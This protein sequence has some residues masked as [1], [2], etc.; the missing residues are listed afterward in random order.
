MSQEKYSRF[1]F[2]G[3]SGYL[4]HPSIPGSQHKLAAIGHTAGLA[5]WS[6]DWVHQHESS[7]EY[8]LLLQGRLIFQIMDFSIS[9]QPNE[10]LVVQP[11]IPHAVL[12]GSGPIEH[13]GMR[14]PILDDKKALSKPDQSAAFL[15]EDERLLCAEWGAR[16]PLDR[17]EYQNCWLIGAGSAKFQSSHMI[18]AY[19]DFPTLQAAA[20]ADKPDR[21]RLHF[22][23]KSWE[24]YAVL[25]GSMTL[26][27]GDALAPIQAGELVEVPPQVKHVLH[28]RQ[29]P[30]KGFT[31]RVP[32]ELQDKVEVEA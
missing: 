14:A 23:Q 20:R 6:D 1:V 16:I 17:P 24:Y 32:V 30:F 18:L 21:H 8:Y 27:I 25:Q 19:L 4:V 12:G 11:Q 15:F 2:E 3:R 26:Q 5:A 7:D 9:L 22:H 28:S 13:L 10:L 29:V 31:L